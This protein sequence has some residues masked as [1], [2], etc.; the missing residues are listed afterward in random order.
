MP[1]YRWFKPNDPHTWCCIGGLY[2]RHKQLQDAVGMEARALVLAPEL[3]DAWFNI[4]SIYEAVGQVDDAR[5]AFATAQLTGLAFR[6]T[7]HPTP[8]GMQTFFR[9]STTTYRKTHADLTLTPCN[10]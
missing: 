10:N 7:P 8:T 2:Q 1:T 5:E 4:G 6:M 9:S 3:C